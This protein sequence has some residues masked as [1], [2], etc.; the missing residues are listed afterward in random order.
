MLLVNDVSKLHETV[1]INPSQSICGNC[2]HY[3][4]PSEIGHFTRYPGY[5]SLDKIDKIPRYGCGILWKYVSSDYI[6]LN[7]RERYERQYPNLEW[8]GW[9]ETKFSFEDR[10][11][12]ES[13][14][15]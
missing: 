6:G 13:P 10:D 15:G 5:V 14:E 9:D 11:Y 1:I 3:A 8:N 7:L 4:N 2:G 12:H